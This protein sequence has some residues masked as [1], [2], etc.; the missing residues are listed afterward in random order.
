MNNSIIIDIV[1]TYIEKIVKDPLF[2][3][4]ITPDFIDDFNKFLISET[5]KSKGKGAIV[6]RKPRK[7]LKVPK[8]TQDDITTKLESMSINGEYNLEKSVNNTRSRKTLSPLHHKTLD[9]EVIEKLGKKFT[10]LKLKA[11]KVLK[12]QQ[13][14]ETPDD[15]F[16]EFIQEFQFE[17]NTQSYTE[18]VQDIIVW[19]P[20]DELDDELEDQNSELKDEYCCSD[21]DL[22]EKNNYSDTDLFGDDF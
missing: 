2:V 12:E 9:K 13:K 3:D 5:S 7:I 18:Q 20:D 17:C 22:S 8:N 14:K 4:K 6:K 1:S 16:I 19:E 11:P 10:S 15:E 21:M